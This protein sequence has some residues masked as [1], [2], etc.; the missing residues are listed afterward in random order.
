MELQAKAA[1]QDGRCRREEG[2][3][4]PSRAVDTIHCA[5]SL[6]LSLSS[7]TSASKNLAPRRQPKWKGAGLFS[8][9][10]PT[11]RLDTSWNKVGHIMARAFGL[12]VNLIFLPSAPSIPRPP[13]RNSPRPSALRP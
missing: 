5:W 13:T 8:S 7:T 3:E 1:G 9:L 12:R 2:R 10:H 11:T 4:E 6:V